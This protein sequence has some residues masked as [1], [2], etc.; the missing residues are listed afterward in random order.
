MVTDSAMS[1]RN[2]DNDIMAQKQFPR[3]WPF[4]KRIHWSQEILLTKGQEHRALVSLWCFP[5]QET[6]E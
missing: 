6:V 5:E 4:V 3:Y 1:G 2:V